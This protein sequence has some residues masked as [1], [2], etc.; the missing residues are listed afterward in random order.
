MLKKGGKNTAKPKSPPKKYIPPHLRKKQKSKTPKKTLKSKTPKK[1][2]PPGLRNKKSP[3]KPKRFSRYSPKKLECIDYQYE[4]KKT[5]YGNVYENRCHPRN[6]ITYNSGLKN[7]AYKCADLR[8]KN[9][10]CRINS[11]M[12]ATPHH[13]YAIFRTE[14]NARE[15]EDIINYQRKPQN[16]TNKKPLYKIKMIN[17]SKS[18]PKILYRSG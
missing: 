9:K 15:C 1:Y 12:P 7:Q 16:T 5:K 17:H 6:Y 3:P 4:C 2:I 8:K 10:Q 14:Q 13:D 11:G 18:T